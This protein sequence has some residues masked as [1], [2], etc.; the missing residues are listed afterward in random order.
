MEPTWEGSEDLL[1][2]LNARTPWGDMSA[3]LWH[4]QL[5]YTVPVQGGSAA[6]VPQHENRNK[7]CRNL[8]CPGQV[9]LFT[10]LKLV[11]LRHWS[12]GQPPPYTHAMNNARGSEKSCMVPE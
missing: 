6:H 7:T 5:V 3:R 9:E 10:E 11:T 2:M 1:Y 4:D 12:S 8:T